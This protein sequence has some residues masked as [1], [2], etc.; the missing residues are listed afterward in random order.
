MAG[1]TAGDGCFSVGVRKSPTVKTGFQ[2]QL[3]YSLTQ[4]HDDK[5]LMKS[6]INF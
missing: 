5:E 6:L 2:V 1:F 3:R 4:H